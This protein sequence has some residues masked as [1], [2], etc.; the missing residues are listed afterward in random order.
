MSAQQ[1]RDPAASMSLLTQL[2]VNPLDAGYYQYRGQRRASSVWQRLLVGVVSLA[3]GMGGTVAVSSLR[4]PSRLD[5]SD[6]LGT[7]A[8]GRAEI[9]ENLDIDI[10]DLRQKITALGGQDPASVITADF[11]MML[12]TATS[13]AKGKGLVVTVKGSAPLGVDA[14]RTARGKVRDHDLRMIVNALWSAKAEAVAVNGIRIGPGSFIRTAGQS[15]LVNITP[16]QPPYVIEAIGDAPLMSVS[17]I[18]GET[19]DY[20][21][22]IESIHG[23]SIAAQAIEN[24]ELPAVEP[25]ALRFTTPQLTT[26]QE[27]QP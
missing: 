8:R 5:V 1:E 25:R 20:L 12:E 18:Q 27:N 21:S 26:P 11:S 24:L 15:V 17:L 19:G 7:Q 16:I 10:K 2:L 3:L 4:S 6:S 14:D 22:S 13:P 23:I 9:V